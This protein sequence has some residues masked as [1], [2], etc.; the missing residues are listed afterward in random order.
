MPEGGGRNL[1]SGEP[2]APGSVYAASVDGEGVV[3]LYRVEVALA[4]GG[5]R[6]RTAG[7][8]YQTLGESLRRADA[9]LRTH[10]VALGI[11]QDAEASDLT[12]QCIDL[13]GGRAGAE[14]GVAFFVAMVSALRRQAVQP[15]LLVLGD[16]TVQGTSRGLPSLVESLQ[17]AMDNGAKRA[18]LPLENKR[19]FLEVSGDIMEK[20]DPVFYSD[21]LTAAPPAMGMG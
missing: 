12:V 15:A 5:G 16:M 10:R 6:L 21:C 3:A 2:R 19:Q 14:I 20:V 18:L 1:I 8:L 13:L 4:A 7:G 9:F 11:A 17:V